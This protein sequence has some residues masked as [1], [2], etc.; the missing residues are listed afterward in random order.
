M[1]SHQ[2]LMETQGG[3]AAGRGLAEGYLGSDVFD[4]KL[5][6]FLC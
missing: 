4:F 1:E 5:L 6:L 3:T 2:R